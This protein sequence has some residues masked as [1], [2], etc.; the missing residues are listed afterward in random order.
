MFTNLN[1]FLVNTFTCEPDIK[2]LEIE[3]AFI[4]LITIDTLELVGIFATSLD[5][6]P[7]N[8]LDNCV[9]LVIEFKVVLEFIK[10]LYMLTPLKKRSRVKFSIMDYHYHF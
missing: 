1:F 8:I 10:V 4:M 2:T 7:V 3:D 5:F 9:G 6:I